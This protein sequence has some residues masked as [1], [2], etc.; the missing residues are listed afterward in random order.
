MYWPIPSVCPEATDCPS[1]AAM[2]TYTPLRG[3]PPLASM[4]VPLIRALLAS[5]KLTPVLV[6]PLAT[7]TSVPTDDASSKQDPTQAT[8][9]KIWLM[10]RPTTL[11]N[12][13]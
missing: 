7:A 12:A 2:I 1:A 13:L 6:P 5:A 9:S 3:A 4:T 11:V 10:N 8:L